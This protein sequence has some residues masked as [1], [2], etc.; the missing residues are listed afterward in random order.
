M[1]QSL[2]TDTGSTEALIT[3][4]ARL[5]AI[6]MKSANKNIFRALLSLSSANL[7][8][9]L[10]GLVNLITVTA[11]FGQGPQMDA[12][13][14]ASTLPILLGQLLG[15]SLEAS[16]IP[17]YAALR[18]KGGKEKASR[19]FSTLLNLFIISAILLTVV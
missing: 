15:S 11:L 1:S 8:I 12:Y 18:A 2:N 9:R 14:V 10:V 16:I 5:V 6:R 3:P 19:F 13:V 4:S 7:L 17:T